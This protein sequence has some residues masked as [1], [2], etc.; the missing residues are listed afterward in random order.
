GRRCQTP[1]IGDRNPNVRGFSE[2]AAINAPIQGG[3]ADIIKRAMIRLPAALAD[4]DL[5]ATMLLQ[6][7]DELIFE[8]PDKEVEDTKAVVKQ[9]MEGAAHLD[10][11]LVVDAGSGANWAEAH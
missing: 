11:P 8:V 7:H 4:A 2:R 9:I 5:S 10:V 6:V 1:G 3:A